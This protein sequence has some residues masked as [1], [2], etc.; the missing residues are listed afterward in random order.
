M[1]DEYRTSLALNRTITKVERDCGS[2][3]ADTRIEV[4]ESV[5][6]T[7]DEVSG[8]ASKSYIRLLPHK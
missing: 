5:I 1:T 3:I 2:R 4:C 8:E 7:K 6:P